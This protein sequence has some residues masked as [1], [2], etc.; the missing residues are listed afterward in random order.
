MGG[1]NAT[2]G[3]EVEGVDELG[4]VVNVEQIA[5]YEGKDEMVGGE[6][7]ED[8]NMAF[9]SSSWLEGSVRPETAMA[10]EFGDIPAMDGLWP[11]MNF[12]AHTAWNEPLE[13]EAA[14]EKVST[15]MHEELNIAP[16][17]FFSY[18]QQ[19]ELPAVTCTYASCTP[20]DI[21][22][23]VWCRLLEPSCGT[24]WL[25]GVVLGDVDFGVGVLVAFDYSFSQ[26]CAAEQSKYMPWLQSEV[27]AGILE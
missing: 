25:C 11:E 14:L 23:C 27:Q 13:F 12:P 2:N 24:P 4:G 5:T 18:C 19:S 22:L 1:E 26:T 21:L 8:T 3:V 20:Y 6:K 17:P 16:D 7:D 9:Y 15:E 10:Y